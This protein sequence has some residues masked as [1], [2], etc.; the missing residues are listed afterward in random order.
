MQW[1]RAKNF[2][3]IFF[4]LVNI[5]LAALI[6]YETNEHILSR[7]REN[8]IHAVFAQN[9]ISMR[10]PIPRQFAPMRALQVASYNY[11]IDRLLY[12]FFPPHAEIKITTDSNRYEFTWEDLRLV[13][14]MAT[15]YIAF[16]SGQSLEGMPN[17]NAAIALTQTFIQE[18]YPGFRLDIQ[19][20][21]I[22]RQGLRIF[23]RQEYQGNLIDINFVEFLVIG[24]GNDLS[25]AQV[26]IQYNAPLGF[27]YMPQELVGPDE[28]LLTF[29]QHMRRHNDMSVVIT[30]MD[31]AYFPPPSGLRAIYIP[32]TPIYL[33]PFYRIFIEGRE[34]PFRINAYTNQMQ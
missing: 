24:E 3:L 7:E 27:A 4:G 19:S 5:L 22:V 20:T 33:E 21:R 11:D 32:Y 17:K 8:A 9:N 2:M 18:H 28:A 23:Y 12:I 14:S 6:H 15:G 29:V 1:D 10:Y 30:H 26:D 25:I 31:I 13:I 34:E 16:D